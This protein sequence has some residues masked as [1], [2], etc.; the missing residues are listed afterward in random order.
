MQTQ[1]EVYLR[2]SSN[3]VWTYKTHK[4]LLKRLDM[5][6]QYTT[7]SICYVKL[8]TDLPGN[9]GIPVLLYRD[10]YLESW[11]WTAEPNGI[12]DKDN[13]S[14]ITISR[15]HNTPLAQALD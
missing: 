4:G 15:Q 3:P 11:G 10:R 5:L 13:P 9:P 6:A 7:L 1:Y 12:P 8:N 14:H 2:D